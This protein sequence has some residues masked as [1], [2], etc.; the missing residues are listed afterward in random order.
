WLQLIRFTVFYPVLA[1][2]WAQAFCF[3]ALLAIGAY[4]RT[5]STG[6]LAVVAA[7]SAVGVAFREI[8]LLVPLAFL[9]SRNPR[10]TWLRHWPFVRVAP[11]PIR[12][13]I[14]LALAAAVLSLV[15]QSVEATDSGFS[16][17]THLLQRALARST[18]S[19]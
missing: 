11:A 19:Y 14:P 9:F 16:A 13:W 4:Q 3:A 17:S 2:A 6:T 10:A 12:E 18:L 15:G 1:D 7:L 5:P 8:V